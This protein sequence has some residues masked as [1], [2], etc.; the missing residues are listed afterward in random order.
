MLGTEKESSEPNQ[1]VIHHQQQRKLLFSSKNLI[2]F[3]SYIFQKLA[4]YFMEKGR[5]LQ[6]KI[7]DVMRDGE[8]ITILRKWFLMTVLLNSFWQ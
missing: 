3:I 6:C 2:H 4:Y 8:I 5:E 1:L 7:I